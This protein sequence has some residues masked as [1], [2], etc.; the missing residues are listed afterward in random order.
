[1]NFHCI[2]QA[3][4]LSSYLMV[5]EDLILEKFHVFVDEN[6]IPQ[7]FTITIKEVESRA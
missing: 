1:M 2:F 3:I 7:V 4:E 6:T 5:K